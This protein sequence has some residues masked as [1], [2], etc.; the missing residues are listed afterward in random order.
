MHVP[1]YLPGIEEIK[2]KST[3]K[4]RETELVDRDL[5]SIGGKRRLS[6]THRRLPVGSKSRGSEEKKCC[7]SKQHHH[8]TA[9]RGHQHCHIFV[10]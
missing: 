7:S 10:S 9:G 2:Q 3:V 6:I 5:T 8:L 1:F 4:L